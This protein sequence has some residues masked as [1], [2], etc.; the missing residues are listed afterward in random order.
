MLVVVN[1]KRS[2]MKTFEIEVQEVLTRLINIEAKNK[3]D[4]ILKAKE[5]Y[6][7]EE[8]VLDADDHLST[9]F[10]LIEDTFDTDSNK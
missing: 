3:S 2:N 9:E 4:A 8:I 1:I 6:N 10:I 5:M 7:N